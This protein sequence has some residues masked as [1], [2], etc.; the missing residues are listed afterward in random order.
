MMTPTTD[1]GSWRPAAAC[2]LPFE[3]GPCDAL[4]PVYAFVDGA[5]VP[6]T[7]GGCEGNE[8]RFGTLEECLVACEGRPIPNGCPA[9]RIAQEICLACGS[10]G[11]CSE[12]TTVCA[13]P[14]DADAGTPTCPS[15]LPICYA[16]ICQITFCH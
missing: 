14:C 5:C 13:L 1:A 12:V 7:Y 9:G 6:R 16:G 3:V 8:N 15:S 10:V 2:A 4:F 11:G